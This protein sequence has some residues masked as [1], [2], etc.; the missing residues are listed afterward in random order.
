MDSEQFGRPAMSENALE[1]ISRP[2]KHTCH[3]G[4]PSVLAFDIPSRPHGRLCQ[5]Q[6]VNFAGCTGSHSAM[7]GPLFVASDL[8]CP[9]D[10]KTGHQEGGHN[11]HDQGA[12]NGRRRSY[13]DRV[14]WLVRAFPHRFSFRLRLFRRPVA[15]S[16]SPPTTPKFVRINSVHVVCH[17]PYSSA[18]GPSRPCGLTV[19]STNPPTNSAAPMTP[20]VPSFSP[21]IT[22]A[23]IDATTGSNSDT[24]LATVGVSV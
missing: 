17:V 16:R 21:N 15:G 19:K 14:G 6:F 24:I 18:K 20:M 13:P 3:C 23:K 8:Q 12:P 1:G 5:I 4:P 11:N 9:A 2:G 22:Q 10:Q 7:A